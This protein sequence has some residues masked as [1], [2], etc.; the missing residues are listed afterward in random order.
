MD[1][2]I[3]QLYT[4]SEIRVGDKLSVG[5]YGELSID[6]AGATQVL[7]RSIRRD[8]RVYTLNVINALCIRVQTV[9][10]DAM[11]ATAADAVSEDDK[12]TDGSNVVSTL[13]AACVAAVAGLRT[14]SQTYKIGEVDDATAESIMRVVSVLTHTCC[15]EPRAP[16]TYTCTS[17][18]TPLAVAGAVGTPR[19]P[20]SPPAS[21]ASVVPKMPA[22]QHHHTL[23]SRS[24]RKRGAGTAAAM[25]PPHSEVMGT[26]EAR[27]PITQASAVQMMPA[28]AVVPAP[29]VRP[30]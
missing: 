10:F 2:V 30:E 11:N 24:W 8:C 26:L 21:A 25:G 4:L 9:V 1:D 5:S 6:R 29:S 3:T 12:P 7:W 16:K 17:T 19:L 13:R 15:C 23:F 20:V 28:S 22:Q 14:L 27:E 18:Q